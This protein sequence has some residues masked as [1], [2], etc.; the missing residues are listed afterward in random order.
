M[1]YPT[2][3]QQKKIS[4]ELFLPNEFRAGAHMEKKRWVKEKI[5]KSLIQLLP[6]NT[7]VF[8][9]FCVSKTSKT[10]N[11]NSNNSSNSNSSK[12]DGSVWVRHS[13]VSRATQ[14]FFFFYSTHFIP[15]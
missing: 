15:P 11:S 12:K 5:E 7:R 3:A 1:V 4:L 14:I 8:L 2:N 10:N 6:L 9:M 13:L